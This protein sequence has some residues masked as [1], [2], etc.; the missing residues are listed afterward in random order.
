MKRLFFAFILISFVSKAQW[1]P[2]NGPYGG[3]VS[4]LLINNN[5]ILSGTNCGIFKSINDGQSWSIS[6][7][8]M[9]IC[10]SI[11]ALVFYNTSIIAGTN[12]GVYI[13]NDNGS[14]WIASSTGLTDL[15]IICFFVDGA[16]IFVS[17]WGGVFKSTNGGLNWSSS[18]IGIPGNTGT[19]SMFTKLGGNIFAAHDQGVFKSTDNGFSWSL[20]N[21]G[22]T[23]GNA[24][25]IISVGNK[26]FVTIL[27]GLF[28]SVDGGLNWSPSLSNLPANCSN[29]FYN[30]SA[31]YVNAGTGIFKSLNSGSSWSQIGNVKADIF[32]YSNSKLYIG[33]TNG[34]IIAKNNETLW[35]NNGL[36]RGAMANVVLK[37][38]N[39]LFCG[40]D[41]GFYF[42]NDQGNVWSL[43]NNGLPLNVEIKCMTQKG[44]SIFVGTSTNGVYRS[45]DLGLT[46][47]SV[48]SGL[49]TDPIWTFYDILSIESIGSDIFIGTSA[50]GS[51]SA[52]TPGRIFKSSDN[53]TNWININNGINNGDNFIYVNDI[54]SIGTVIYLA[55]Y[56]GLFLSTN[57]GNSWIQS[58]SGM[59]TNII[60]SLTSNSNYLFAGHSDA[61]SSTQA[62]FGGVFVSNDYGSNW[63]N[64]NYPTNSTVFSLFSLNE[65]VYGGSNNSNIMVSSDNGNSWQYTGP[66]LNGDVKKSINGDVNGLF[67]AVYSLYSDYD[68]SYG[69][70]KYNGVLDVEEI[71]VKDFSNLIYPNP[72]IS[73]IT[74][75]GDFE[76]NEPYCIFDQ[77]GREVFSGKLNEI[78]T[79]INLSFL[80]RGFYIFKVKGKNINAQ[81]VKE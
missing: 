59:S 49:N 79:D 70:Y 5:E 32:Q 57:G 53:G 2:T 56:D 68:F 10:T 7:N 36:G 22:L 44:N 78:S 75:K 43:R 27:D 24:S 20:S 3:L 72:T 4:S 29:L 33:N 73:S 34:V 66:G 11:N 21:N 77:M 45:D 9:P 38:G 6:S 71:N 81:I 61:S 37:N 58:N 17:T 48:N 62:P 42:S 26:I 64:N 15:N 31:I 16:N 80:P 76:M 51:G 8:G 46:W 47:L 55:T 40:T 13:S 28:Y 54:H 60:L 30:G 52:A 18:N 35:S 67:T 50:L 41:N 19:I 25:S 14:N 63:G 65:S 74:V 69:V 12:N 39:N 23:S 1:S